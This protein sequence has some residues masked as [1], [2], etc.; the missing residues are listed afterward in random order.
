MNCPICNTPVYRKNKKAC[1][2]SHEKVLAAKIGAGFHQEHRN[3]QK[4]LWRDIEKISA[5]YDECERI[6]KETGIKHHVDH[7]IPLRGKTVTGLHVH[8]NLRIIAAGE[9]ITKSNKFLPELL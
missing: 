8:E 2:P 9:N 6:S 5:I 3:R 4:P 1:K 7:I